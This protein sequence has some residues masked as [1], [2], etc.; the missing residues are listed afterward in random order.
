MTWQTSP[1]LRALFGIDPRSLALFR[2]G[3]GALLILDL[4]IRLPDL[5]A[6]Y[7]DDG[8]FPR[9]LIRHHYASV[10]H[11]SFHFLS[12]RWIVQ[13]GLFFIAAMLALALLAGFKTRWAVIGSW[14]MLLSIHHRVPP[15]LSGADTLLRMLLF[16][17]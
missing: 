10:W 3:L 9:A 5:A 14:L 8:M 12:G 7:T 1:T 13:A 11:W 15:I 4:L 2:I 17:A 6:M 16:W